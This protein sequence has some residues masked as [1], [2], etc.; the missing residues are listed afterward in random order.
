M[1]D[2]HKPDPISA[3]AALG[4]AGWYLGMASKYEGDGKQYIDPAIRMLKEALIALEG[5]KQ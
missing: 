5:I 4:S 2:E 3:L 1:I